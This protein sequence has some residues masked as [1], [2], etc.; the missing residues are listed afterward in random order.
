MD[1]ALDEIL[2]RTATLTPEQL[3]SIDPEELKEIDAFL[4]RATHDSLEAKCSQRVA[5]FDAGPLYW[6]TNLTQTKTRNMRLRAFRSSLRF[7]KRVTLP[8]CSMRF[9][10]GYATLFIPEV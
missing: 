5:S 4:R 10:R 6:L 8:R 3:A 1:L 7:R 2:N 9:L